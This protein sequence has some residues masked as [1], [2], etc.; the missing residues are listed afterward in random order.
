MDKPGKPGRPRKWNS[1]AERMRARRA[2]QRADRERYAEE[3][4]S[5]V[6][7]GTVV[8]PSAVA[9][10]VVSNFP[11]ADTV[12]DVDR[13]IKMLMIACQVEGGIQE[14]LHQSCIEQH[15]QLLTRF[16]DEQEFARDVMAEAKSLEHLVRR[17]R[18][19]LAEV[20]P[21]GPFSHRF[22]TERFPELRKRV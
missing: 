18:E 3:R 12:H 5:E 21:D 11:K 4:R 10:R 19:R 22:V 16:I 6:L 7:D 9:A 8:L 15:D 20:D 1:D 14:W 13:I 17:M 2:A